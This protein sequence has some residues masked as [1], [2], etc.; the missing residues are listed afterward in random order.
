MTGGTYVVGDIHGCYDDWI[1]LKNRIEA[2]DSEAKFIL[3]GDIID[4]GPGTINM[5]NWAMDNI[6]PGGKYQMVI[7]NHELEKLH[8]WNRVYSHIRGRCKNDKVV[9]DWLITDNYD[10]AYQFEKEGLT[11]QDMRDFLD[12]CEKLPYI[13]DTTVDGNRFI[14]VHANLP[15]VLIDKENYSVKQ[16]ETPKQK[17][18][19]VWDRDCGDFIKIPNA[20][21]IHGHNASVFP[22][23]FHYTLDITEDDLGKIIYM[24]N[25]INLDCGL[26]YRQYD[27]PGNL[28]AIRL[29]DLQ[30]YYLY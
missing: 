6:K 14:I 10:F 13:I 26:V 30:E 25:R 9:T 18:F 19:T 29:N 8:M 22:D 16:P 15:W 23:S 21:L 4:R 5:I 17:E 2:E 11:W 28:A 20:M 27:K 7:G 1:T 24:H 12:W 3:V